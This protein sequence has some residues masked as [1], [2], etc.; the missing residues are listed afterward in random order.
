MVPANVKP[1]AVEFEG[2]Q[3]GGGRKS[4]RMDTEDIIAIGAV[5]CSVI[6]SIGITIGNV[7]I[8]AGGGVVVGLVGVSG[9]AELMKAKRR[10]S[11]S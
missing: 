10:G 2:N 5:M 4:F 1:L 6:L 8:V 11:G 9:L 3:A 7:D